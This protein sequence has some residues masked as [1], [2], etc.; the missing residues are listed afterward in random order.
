MGAYRDPDEAHIERLAA[1]LRN[2]APE[3]REE[4][5]Q[6]AIARIEALSLRSPTSMLTASDE[7][8]FELWRPIFQELFGFTPDFS[9]IKLPQA[10]GNLVLPI[11]MPGELVDSKGGFMERIFGICKE[12]FPSRKYG[13]NLDKSVTHNDRT[14]QNGSY[15]VRVGNHLK[16]TDGDEILKGLSANAIRQKNIATITLPERKM[17][18][19]Y[20][21]KTTGNH[22]DK[23]VWT[24]CSGSRDS[25]GFVPYA[26]WY[27]DAFYVGW[28]HPQCAYPYLRGRSAVSC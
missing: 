1:I 8:A 5:F 11:L 15:A 24:L 10:Q 12:L 19:I 16:A 7:Q 13:S 4:F 26:Y 21:Y 3:K 20:I 22:L 23:H 14:P 17:L 2:V 18:E 6:K 28:C 27:G 9:L 25:G